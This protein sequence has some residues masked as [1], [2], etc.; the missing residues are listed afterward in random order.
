MK[1]KPIIVFFLLVFSSSYANAPSLLFTT[2]SGSI[3]FTSD[4]PL[5]LIQAN[6]SQL[7]GWLNSDSKQFSFAVN[8]RSFKGFKVSAQQKHFNENYLE[9]DKYP[10]ASFEGK[11]IEDLDLHRDGL[12]SIRAKGNLSIHGVVQERIIKCS[13]TIKNGQV[14][15][16]A[17]FIVLLVDHN[18]TIP[19]ILSQKL[20][21]DIKIEVKTDL[22]EK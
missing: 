15:V 4:A 8:I 6:S 2:N 16:K 12:Y 22:V 5:E 7:K 17:N 9:S 11:I 21:S 13:L 10:Q 19:K 18:I 3:V 20:A 1:I 14:N